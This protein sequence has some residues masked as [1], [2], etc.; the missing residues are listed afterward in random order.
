ML[1]P[2]ARPAKERKSLTVEQARQI[3]F[4]AI[5]VDRNPAMWLTG[6]M[7]GLRPG[8]LAGLRWPFVEIDSEEPAIEVAERAQEVSQK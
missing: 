7:C 4:Y 1:L 6:L 3:L 8:E 5:P 2:E